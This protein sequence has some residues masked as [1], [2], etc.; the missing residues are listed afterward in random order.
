MNEQS[1]PRPTMSLVVDATV[2]EEIDNDTGCVAFEEEFQD[3]LLNNT[4]VR[5]IFGF[6]YF[7]IWL[8]GVGGNTLVIYVAF[9]RRLAFNIRSIF[10]IT[11]AFS[12]I[13]VGMTS[14]P[15]TAI[16]MFTKI[17]IFPSFLCYCIGFF[18][19]ISIFASSFTLCC[20]AIDRYLLVAYPQR[21]FVTPV[22]ASICL[23]FLFGIGVVL[24]SPM[25]MYM[26]LET[27]ERT[28]GVYC[29]EEWPRHSRFS[30]QW[31]GLAVMILQFGLPCAISALC[32]WR[33][34]I[35]LKEQIQRRLKHEVLMPTAE[36]RL[37]DRR[38]RTT[39]MMA[40]MVSGFVVFWFPL[41]LINSL[42][43]FTPLFSDSNE[44][45][46]LFAAAHVLAMTSLVSN[47]IIYCWF[48]EPFRTA[49]RS[50]FLARKLFDSIDHPRR[51]SLKG[52]KRG[53]P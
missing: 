1:T 9:T 3:D 33:I 16:S 13:F 27:Y 35:R 18:Q 5:V 25:A 22:T 4:A 48:N 29:Q 46:L 20:I 44:F 49:L 31:Y 24:A 50:I 47:P 10:I 38:R 30:R 11:L 23:F 51:D 40:L 42:R 37:I 7:A 53:G 2:F 15:I 14:L 43:D 8:F 6:L 32:Y 52:A 21:Q 41:N 39:R 17:W 28:C 26:K 45:G 12:D 34:S 19:A 36:R